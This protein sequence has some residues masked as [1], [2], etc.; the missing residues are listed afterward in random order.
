M[1]NCGISY[2]SFTYMVGRRWNGP[3]MYPLAHLERSV[4][5]VRVE[6]VAPCF[7]SQTRV[8]D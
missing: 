1:E 3:Q 5:E 8:S 6:P 7:C 2:D 4:I